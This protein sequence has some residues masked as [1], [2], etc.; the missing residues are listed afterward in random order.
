MKFRQK[1]DTAA[2]EEALSSAENAVFQYGRR[3]LASFRPVVD[4]S[5]RR[6]LEEYEDVKFQVYCKYS[7]NGYGSPEEMLD[8]EPDMREVS[9][10]ARAASPEKRPLAPGT[11]RGSGRS[12]GT[13]WPWPRR[14][15][16]RRG[17][18]CEDWTRAGERQSTR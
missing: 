9:R 1:V 10:A 12:R 4:R 7:A 11:R 13:S 16:R 18:A 5:A 3:L 8:N 14:R 6:D 2:A 17:A 15:M